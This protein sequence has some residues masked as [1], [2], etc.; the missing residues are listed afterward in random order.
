[1]IPDKNGVVK[2][3]EHPTEIM[4]IISDKKGVSHTTRSFALIQCSIS[5][6]VCNIVCQ[7]MLTEFR[8]HF[9]L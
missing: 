1:M 8:G 2:N 9:T 6:L 3:S 4:V 7:V 5:H